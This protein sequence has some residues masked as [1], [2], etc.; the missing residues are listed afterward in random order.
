M[1]QVTADSATVITAGARALQWPLN[2]AETAAHVRVALEEDAA[3]HDVSTLATVRSDRHAHATLVARRSGVIAGIPLAIEAF[4][5]LDASVS[6]RVAADDGAA[7]AAGTPVLVLT[8]HARGLL[9]A[10]RTAL[11]YLQHLSGIATLTHAF[12]SRLEGLATRVLDTRKTR[13]GWRHLEKYAVRAGGG[14]NHR[15]DLRS[16]VLIKDN[17]LAAVDGRIDLAVS[18]A[19]ALAADGALVQVE[20]DTLDQVDAAL[21]AGADAVLLDNMSTEQ[22]AAAVTRIGGRAITEASGG[23]TLDTVR[24]IAASGVDRV[25]IGALT[26][27]APALD[28]ALDFHP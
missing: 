12:V 18:R 2:G 10:E 6:I 22:L 23:V 11:N 28:L 20:C 24:A 5:Q 16:A 26:H 15:L 21:S 17:H 13:P 4:R 3:F 25:S 7:V 14:V 19:R 8:G 1:E 9:S 27:S